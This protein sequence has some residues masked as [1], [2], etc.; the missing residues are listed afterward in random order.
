MNEEEFKERAEVYGAYI[1]S[2]HNGET[3]CELFEEEFRKNN[4]LMRKYTGSMQKDKEVFEYI[5][6]GV[7]SERIIELKRRAALR[8]ASMTLDR[9]LDAMIMSEN[10]KDV[11]SN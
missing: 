2:R 8:F 1:F 6:N 9:F 5:S 7:S 4:L 3:T 10:N 11:E